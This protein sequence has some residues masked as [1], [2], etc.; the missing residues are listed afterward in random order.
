VSAL[1]QYGI[2]VGAADIDADAPQG[3]APSSKT[4]WKSRS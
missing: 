2:G 4:E 3:Y 1:E